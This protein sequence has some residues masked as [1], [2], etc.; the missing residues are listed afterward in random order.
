MDQ[1]YH[2]C[3]DKAYSHKEKQWIDSKWGEAMKILS[4]NTINGPKIEN[5]ILKFQVIT[6]S[7]QWI[8]QISENIFC[9]FH[10]AYLPSKYTLLNLSFQGNNVFKLDDSITFFPG[11]VA[12]RSSCCLTGSNT[13]MKLMKPF[14]K[15]HFPCLQLIKTNY[16][17][18]VK[19]RW[20]C[21]ICFLWFL[22]GLQISG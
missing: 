1:I 4:T 2:L 14:E 22:Y 3:Q 6:K 15:Y 20:S 9:H 21:H 13:A 16:S 7:V 8:T 19:F 18:K 10:W 17:K 12:Q 5:E 11:K